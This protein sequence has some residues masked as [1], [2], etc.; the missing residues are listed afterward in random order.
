MF[1]FCRCE[2]AEDA[3]LLMLRCRLGSVFFGVCSRSDQSLAAAVPKWRVEELS[4]Q[5]EMEREASRHCLS[6]DDDQYLTLVEVVRWCEKL[7]SAGSS[8]APP[9]QLPNKTRQDN[10]TEELFCGVAA[11]CRSRGRLVLFGG[12]FEAFT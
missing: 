5:M 7:L 1:L 6:G 9:T 11:S 4:A 12:A 10:T 3:E 8:L 2:R